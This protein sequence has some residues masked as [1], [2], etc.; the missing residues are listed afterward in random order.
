MHMRCGLAMLC[1][2]RDPHRRGIVA[3]DVGDN[4][5]RR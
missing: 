5:R 3:A 4:E 1:T 2:M